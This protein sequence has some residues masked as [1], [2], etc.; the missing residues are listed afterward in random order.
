MKLHQP[1]SPR[2]KKAKELYACSKCPIS[3]DFPS[4]LNR[5]LENV[6][7]LNLKEKS[8]SQPDIEPT[9]TFLSNPELEALL[10][11]YSQPK[12][13]RRKHVFVPRNE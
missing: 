6:H 8:S 9:T 10:P 7:G 12:S 4:H 13:N 2:K 5:H 1:K 3:F 11:S